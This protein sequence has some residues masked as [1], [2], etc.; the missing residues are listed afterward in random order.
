M[1]RTLVALIALSF[2]VLPAVAADLQDGRLTRLPGM[3]LPGMVTREANGIPHVFAFNRHDLY[4]LNGWM[5]ANDRLFQM[6]TSRRIAS[7]TLGELLGSPALSNDVQLRTLGLRRAAEATLPTLSAQGRAAVDAY[8][9]GVN[10][11]LSS[12]PLPPEY[13][14]LEVTKIAP[15]SSTDSGTAP[16]AP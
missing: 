15:W 14:L 16:S 10:A 1:K 6:D 7:G 11:W 13:G 2:V 4:F 5:H 3:L 9:E 8:S 12:H